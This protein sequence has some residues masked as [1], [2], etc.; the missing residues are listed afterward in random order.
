MASAPD[1]AAA[2]MG[3]I[4]GVE[5]AILIALLVVLLRVRS[6]HPGLIS[7]VMSCG[8]R[9]SP[10]RAGLEPGARKPSGALIAVG[11]A[12]GDDASPSSRP[13]RRSVPKLP[14]VDDGRTHEW[15]IDP[16]RLRKR[17][18]IGKGNF[19]EV[20]LA[21]W[22][23]SPVAVKTMLAELQTKERLVKRFV[24]EITLMSTL[25]HPN[26]VLF[27]GACTR[28]PN[29]CLVLEYCVHGSLH[30][31]LK[32]EHT[33][34]VRIT[35][36][37]IYRFA[38]D[39]ARGVY[40]LHKR[41]SV[42]QRDLKAR[43][44]LV[45]ESLN[46]KVADF[47]LSRVLDESEKNKLTACG[48]PAWTAPEIVK[49]ERYTD[50]VDVYSFAIIMWEL[51]TR[52]EPYGGQ[53]GVQIAYA[54]AEQGLRPEIPA[55]CPADYADLMR[56]CW[57]SDPHERPTFQVILKRLF[58]LKKSSDTA[59]AAASM[60]A[61]RLPEVTGGSDGEGWDEPT[62][63]ERAAA[64][65][66]AA[67]PSHSHSAGAALSRRPVAA[68]A[69]ALGDPCP[70]I[71]EERA[72]PM[73]GTVVIT[74]RNSTSSAAPP[75]DAPPMD[76][77]VTI[78]VALP[79]AVTDVTDAAPPVV[80]SARY[81]AAAAGYAP[82][83][84]SSTAAHTPDVPSTAQP[85]ATHA[86]IAAGFMLSGSNERFVPGD[87]VGSAVDFS[88]H[89]RPSRAPAPPLYSARR[90]VADLERTTEPT[91]AMTTP[92]ARA[93]AAGVG[94]TASSARSATSTHRARDTPIDRWDGDVDSESE[95]HTS[96]EK[97]PAAQ[98]AAVGNRDKQQHT[99]MRSN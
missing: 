39:I 99:Q 36:S 4:A 16:R 52:Q 13:R 34:G 2:A 70:D 18:L 54:A 61:Q 64:S 94:I 93:D 62:A 35:M 48:T 79:G 65:P 71:D 60:S 47:G 69:I 74:V 92:S 41:C 43:N 31:F 26:V 51:I 80:A 88:D 59:A 14:T 21:T 3:I 20:W 25:H 68:A 85:T 19:G 10:A 53:K 72:Q 8:E 46:G 24:D 44:I 82:S 89:A 56:Q 91:L 57:A 40:Y 76:D 87:D 49:M 23:G 6:E 77:D 96:G 84:T 66:P 15:E 78:G 33:H 28:R 30:H 81:R 98:G 73:P 5:A 63:G 27:L 17:T 50:K 45:D 37:L 95:E 86:A 90:G 58:Q 97:A 75:S 7:S 42:V 67:S 83:P 12:D 32:A 9:A 55:Y 29:L 11:V 22:L 38:L 1:A